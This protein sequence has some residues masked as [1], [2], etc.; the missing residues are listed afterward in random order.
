[1]GQSHQGF[2]RRGILTTASASII[3]RTCIHPVLP[4]YSVSRSVSG[5]FDG[6]VGLTP[7]PLK[8][9]EIQEVT[10]RP[11]IAQRAVMRLEFD[12]V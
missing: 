12:P 5:C 3:A 6:P 1:M 8:T 2:R 7:F 9:H 4:F 11:R 10:G